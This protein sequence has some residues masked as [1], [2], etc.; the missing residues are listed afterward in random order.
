MEANPKNR[1]PRNNLQK[2]E[3]AKLLAHTPR[4]FS[5]GNPRRRLRA[6]SVDE[7]SLRQDIWTVLRFRSS[8][9]HS[10]GL[11][12]ASYVLE[13]CIL[14]LILLNVVVAISESSAVLDSSKPSKRSDWYGVFLLTSTII[15]SIEYMLRLW[16]CVEDERY[17]GAIIGRLKWM[18]QP[19]SIL[20]LIALLPFYLEICFEFKL[21]P[22][23]RGVVF[24]S[25]RLLRIVSFLRLERSYNA[26]KNLRE[27]F[28]RKKEEFLVVTYLTAVVV[29]TSSTTIFFLENNAQ[30]EVF[31]SVGVSAWWSIETITSLG[32][33]D[34][35]PVTNVGRF[36]GSVLAMCGIIL[37]TIPG[38]VLGSG[39]IEVMLEKQRSEEEEAYNLAFMETCDFSSAPSSQVFPETG[40]D[41][42]LRIQVPSSPPPT[43][44]SSFRRLSPRI[45]TVKKLDH[46]HQK[47]DDMAAKQNDLQQQLQKQ[48]K[49]LDSILKLLET[50][51][52]AQT[53]APARIS[54]PTS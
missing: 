19:L 4:N 13:C 43:S 49:Q 45:A 20:D 36:F 16:S 10:S 31:S 17:Q 46:F 11:Q 37:F 32:Y 54:E 24:R 3:L 1:T 48:Q 29:L 40:Q 42:S 26:L 22:S 30:P 23:Y 6:L 9:P 27:I 47:M 50:L 35:V 41:E 44:N 34:I 5:P 39:F 33:G 28:A 38:A 14:V 51:V 8:I 25:L 21:I 53:R 12:F 18:I 52:A 7:T 15:F 2:G